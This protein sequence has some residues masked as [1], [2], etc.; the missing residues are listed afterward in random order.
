[1]SGYIACYPD[2]LSNKDW[3]GWFDMK[4]LIVSG[5][6]GSGKSIALDTLEDCGYYCIDNL[7][8]TLLEDFIQHVVLED[9]KTYE[10][11]AIGIDARNKTEA[12]A[13]FS[14]SLEFIRSH[15]I[16]CEVLYIQAEENVLLKRYSE[17]RRKHPLT[18]EKIS[19]T[20]ALRIEK[21]MLRPVAKCADIVIDSSH[22]H[23]HQLRE[24]LVSQLGAGGKKQMTIQFL[25]FGYKYGV[26][27]D[28]DFMFDV[29]CLP[30]PFWVPELRPLTGKDQGI[31]DFLQKEDIVTQYFL[32]I[33]NFIERWVP[34][35]ESDNRSYLT[36]AVGC[37]GGRHRSV[38]MVEALARHFKQSSQNV[39]ARHRDLQ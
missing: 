11:T 28:A 7:P 33:R 9:K 5:L 3:N 31:I 2:K 14:D 19:L 30:N 10:K 16:E 18:T 17:T 25:S 38:Y 22:T 4:L 15:G 8:F 35:F 24:I 29:R 6:S 13:N 12:L 26:P 1:M 36:V 21:D 27:L 39:I 23:Y 37:T 34:R 20:E 32:D